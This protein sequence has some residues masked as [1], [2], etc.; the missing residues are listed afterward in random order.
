MI[1]EFELAP[2][3][4]AGDFAG[5]EG[6]GIR[7]RSNDFVGGL[8]DEFDAEAAGAEGEEAVEVFGAGLGRLL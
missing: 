3:I 6:A 7:D 5:A 1:E 8:V 2:E 4:G